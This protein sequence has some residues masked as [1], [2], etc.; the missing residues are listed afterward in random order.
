MNDFSRITAVCADSYNH[1]MALIACRRMLQHGFAEVVLFTDDAVDAHAAV[2]PEGLRLVRIE[3]L[4]GRNA[5]SEFMIRCVHPEIRTPYALVFQWDG[6]VIHPECWRTDF[7][8]YDY[9]GAPW[10][11]RSAYGHRRVGNGGF[12]L[13]SVKLMR[14]AAQLVPAD[15]RQWN[16][17]SFICFALGEILEREFGLRFAPLDVARAFSVENGSVAAY[18]KADPDLAVGP[19][20]GFHGAFNFH[21]A[22]DDEALLHAY[23]ICL[24]HAGSKALLHP[25]LTGN[26]L[27]ALVSS[28]RKPVALQLLGRVCEALGLDPATTT[29]RKVLVD[30]LGFQP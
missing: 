7:L 4:R 12:S 15:I 25:Y 1:E 6:F 5:Y 3:P 27:V 10:P 9:I 18:C 11:R 22:F 26:L 14:A 8:D 21:L 30:H 2:I 29:V 28:G 23:D 20:F 16:E 19:T 17:D 24:R 13:R